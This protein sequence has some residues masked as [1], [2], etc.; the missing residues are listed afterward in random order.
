MFETF[1]LEHPLSLL[2]GGLAF[3]V[4]DLVFDCL[5]V[6]LWRPGFCA[7]RVLCVLFF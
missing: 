5:G 7:S 4:E 6:C 1:G 2:V 3:C